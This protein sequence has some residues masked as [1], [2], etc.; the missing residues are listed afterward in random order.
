MLRR[1]EGRVGAE[2]VH[3]DGGALMRGVEVVVVAARVVGDDDVGRWYVVVECGIV[4]L[5]GDTCRRI[6]QFGSC[7]VGHEDVDGARIVGRE[8]E[9]PQGWMNEAS[10][11]VCESWV[12]ACRRLFDDGQCPLGWRPNLLGHGGD[13]AGDRYEDRVDARLVCRW[14]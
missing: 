6:P 5:S 8:V 7:V 4:E 12:L 9:V 2:G 1:L 11:E 13:R 3:G 14:F 10:P